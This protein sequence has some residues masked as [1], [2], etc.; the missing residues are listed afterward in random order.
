[1]TVPRGSNIQIIRSFQAPPGR[2]AWGA[3]DYEMGALFSGL[4]FQ[5]VYSVIEKVATAETKQRTN[6]N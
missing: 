5:V 4:M 1:M 6:T 2:C 3:C